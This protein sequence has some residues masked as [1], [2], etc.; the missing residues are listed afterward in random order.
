MD[1]ITRRSWLRLAGGACIASAFSSGLARAV[2]PFSSNRFSIEIQGTRSDGGHDVLL[3]PG[4]A[5]GPAIWRGLTPL[6]PGHRAHMLHIA[7]FEKKPAGG[8]AQGKILS[9]IVDELARYIESRNLRHVALIGHSMGGTLAMMLALRKPALI[10]RVMV[11]DM[12]PDGSGM[13]GGTSSGLGYLAAQLNGYF[14]G[15]KAGRQL[16]AD[17]VR[18]TPGGRDSDPRVISQSLAEMA[19]TDLTPRLV[20]FPC[21]LSIIYAVPADTQ[22]AAEQKRRYRTAYTNARNAKLTAIGPSGHMVMLDQPRLFA[23]AVKDFLK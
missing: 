19:Q 6:L 2:T 17:M 14:T 18:K 9:P 21:P 8:N 13:I 15:T 20:S 1:S 10:N 22:M 3:L 11:V 5:S 23:G 12:L 16:L 4:L 7:G